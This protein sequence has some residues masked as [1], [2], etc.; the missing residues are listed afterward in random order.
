[1]KVIPLA[2]DTQPMSQPV[3]GR[4]LSRGELEIFLREHPDTECILGLAGEDR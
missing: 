2:G 1:V 3:A 4:R